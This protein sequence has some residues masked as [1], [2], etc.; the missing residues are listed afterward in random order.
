L[1]WHP[2]PSLQFYFFKNFHGKSTV[3]VQSEQ[4]A[5]HTPHQTQLEKKHPSPAHLQEKKGRPLHIIM[6][7]L[8]G[9]MEIL[10]LKLAANYFWPGLMALPKNTQ[11]IQ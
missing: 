5:V 3:Q 6:Q 8:I 2:H 7:L 9:C 4:Q 10:F 11:P 1:L